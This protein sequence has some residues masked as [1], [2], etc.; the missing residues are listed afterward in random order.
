VSNNGKI[1]SNEGVFSQLDSA[2]HCTDAAGLDGTT[3]L[4][5]M[6]VLNTF[7]PGRL[8]AEETGFVEVFSRS[9]IKKSSEDA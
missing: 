4:L 6:L 1:I 9:N 3:I 5:S 7:H 2:L 8:M